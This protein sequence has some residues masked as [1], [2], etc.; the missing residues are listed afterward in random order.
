MKDI[1]ILKVLLVDQKRTGKWLAEA[2]GNNEAIVSRWCTNEVQLSLGT[3]CTIAEVLNVDIR[4]LL[5][6]K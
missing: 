2:L 5:F 3:L 6:Q 4:E 1:N